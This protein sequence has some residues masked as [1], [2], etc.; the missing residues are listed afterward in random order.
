MIDKQLDDLE[1]KMHWLIDGLGKTG[2]KISDCSFIT[3]EWVIENYNVEN[4]N[5]KHK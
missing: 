5:C 3:W 1:K 2:L 4:Y